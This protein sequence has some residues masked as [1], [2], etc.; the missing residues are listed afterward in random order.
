MS[1]FRR[2]L[3]LFRPHRRAA[4]L[5]VLAMLGVALFTSIVAYLFGPLFDQVLTPAT[6]QGIHQ[7]LGSSPTAARGLDA[8]I[9]HDG[10][11][12]TPVIRFLDGGLIRLQNAL[13]TTPQSRAFVLPL[14][15]FA[16]FVLKNVCAYVA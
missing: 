2:L 13:G 3:Q 7:E 5:A 14:I 6:K 10:V 8:L 16:A 9:G 11:R 1:D 12:Q 15:L 4:I